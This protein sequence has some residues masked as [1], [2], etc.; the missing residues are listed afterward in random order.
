MVFC[1][2]AETQPLLFN[3]FALL[4]AWGKAFSR[5]AIL[6]LNSGHD[7]NGYMPCIVFGLHKLWIN[8]AVNEKKIL[9]LCCVAWLFVCFWA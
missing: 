5:L 4:K 6:A 2:F 8:V 7:R 1:F 9:L 3:I